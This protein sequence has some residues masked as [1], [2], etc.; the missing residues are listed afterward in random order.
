M[1]GTNSGRVSMNGHVRHDCETDVVSGE[2][3]IINLEVRSDKLQVGQ[4]YSLHLSKP[5]Y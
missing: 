2:H 1:I 4:N 5:K 3:L